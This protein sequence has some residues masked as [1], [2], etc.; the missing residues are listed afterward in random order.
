V[1]PPGPTV[2]AVVPARGGS[3]GIPRKNVRPLWGRPLIVYTL[4][5][6]LASRAITRLIVSTDDDETARVVEAHGVPVPFRRPPEL[7]TDTARQIDVVRHALQVAEAG[8]RLVYDVVVLLQP[9]AP[10]RTAA[11]IDGALRTLSE[12]G[13]DSVVSMSEPL[14]DNPFYAHTIEGDRPVPLIPNAT[15]FTRRQEFPRA[16]IRNGA[17]YAAR[18]SVIAAGALAGSDLRVYIMP[19][20][21]SI[22]ID[23]PLDLE[24]AEFLLSREARRSG[25]SE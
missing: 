6:A 15:A 8:D 18:R 12:T 23:T 25:Q 11:D 17:I 5:A 2:L 19:P 22:N 20:E 7:A 1:S 13:A 16:Y 10:L 21:R 4:D 9:T 3:R 24:V 14:I